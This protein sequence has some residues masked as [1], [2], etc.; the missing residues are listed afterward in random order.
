MR[1]GRETSAW[2]GTVRDDDTPHLLPVW[3]VWLDN[4][5]YFVVATESEQFNNLR[6]NQ[7]VSV[8]LPDPD[9]VIMIEGEA[10][11]SDRK[12]TDQLADYFYNKYEFDFTQDPE[13][14]WRLVE[15][16]PTRVLAWG[17]GY[18]HEGIQVL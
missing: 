3:F 1:L 16:T 11:A 18:D 14:D 15:V 13:I 6:G 5:F 17:D 10:H 8:V 2:V 4:T 9:R 7:A 12:T